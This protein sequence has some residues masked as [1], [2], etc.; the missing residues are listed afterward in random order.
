MKS[1]FLVAVLAALSSSVV[2]APV[3]AEEGVP[4]KRGGD[5]AA[6]DKRWQWTKWEDAVDEPAQEKSKRWQWTKWEDAV[7][8]PA[9]EKAKRWQWTKWEDAVDEPAQG[10]SKRWQWTKWEDAVDEK[11]AE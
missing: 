4:A 11:P 7:D 6:V 5:N 3:S 10:K 8:E 2:A 9:Q 1:T